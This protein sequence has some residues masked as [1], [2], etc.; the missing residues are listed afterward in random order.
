MET[1]STDPMDKMLVA[2]VEKIYKWINKLHDIHYQHIAREYWSERTYWDKMLHEP[3][4]FAPVREFKNKV[5]HLK[6]ITNKSKPDALKK[7]KQAKMLKQGEKL[8]KPKKR[9]QS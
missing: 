5:A 7:S 4:T 9:N 1:W 3:S 8:R 6:W 2:H